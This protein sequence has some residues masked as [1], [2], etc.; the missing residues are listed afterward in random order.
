MARAFSSWD[1]RSENPT[2][3]SPSSSKVE[4]SSLLEPNVERLREQYRIPEQYQLFAPGANGRMNS[5]PS[6]QMAFYVEDL[7]TDLQFSIPKFVWNI[8]DYYGLCSVQ[9]AS[10]LV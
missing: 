9:L 4:A 5:P 8:L 3:D 10:N 2:D 1:G 6:D 7:W